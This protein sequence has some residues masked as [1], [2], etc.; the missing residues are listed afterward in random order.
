MVG[1]TYKMQILIA[2]FSV[3]ILAFSAQTALGGTS[4]CVP[5]ATVEVCVEWSQGAAPAEDARA[6]RSVQTKRDSVLG[7]PGRHRLSI[8]LEIASTTLVAQ[9]AFS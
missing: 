7:I 1:K 3:C 6:M 8:P 2:V 5:G 4:T 9:A